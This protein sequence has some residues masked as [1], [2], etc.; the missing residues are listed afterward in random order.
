MA[1]PSNLIALGFGS[2][3]TVVYVP[4]LGMGIGP[5]AAAEHGKYIYRIGN[6]RLI[7]WIHFM[8]K[9]VG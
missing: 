2:W 1:G 7:H 4:T 6:L 5:A 3:S 8:F 9:H